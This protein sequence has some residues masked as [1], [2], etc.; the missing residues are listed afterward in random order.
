MQPH[1]WL[2]RPF[3]RVNSN[4]GT[5]RFNLLTHTAWSH[6]FPQLLDAYCIVQTFSMSL[7]HLGGGIT[8]QW[9]QAAQPW[10]TLCMAYLVWLHLPF[11]CVLPSAQNH[12]SDLRRHWILVYH[13]L[14]C[15]TVI[16]VVFSVS[17]SKMVAPGSGTSL[18]CS[19]NGKWLKKSALE[20]TAPAF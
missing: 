19:S 14:L 2:L 17:I 1:P 9:P 13:D 5:L 6:P 10:C 20:F 15:T 4:R 12:D 18:G 7:A 3:P 11:I 8:T 16:T